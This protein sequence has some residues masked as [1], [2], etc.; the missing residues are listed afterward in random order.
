MHRLKIILENRDTLVLKIGTSLL[1]ALWLLLGWAQ[2]V[3]TPG[4]HATAPSP[5]P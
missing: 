5:S 2:V 4:Q 3:P 1:A